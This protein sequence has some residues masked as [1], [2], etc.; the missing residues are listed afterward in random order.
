LAEV[1]R[2]LWKGIGKKGKPTKGVAQTASSAGLPF[3]A[4][5]LH[6]GQSAGSGAGVVGCHQ[7]DRSQSACQ[8]GRFGFAHSRRAYRRAERRAKSGL[9]YAI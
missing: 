3:G 4:L 9:D 7:L 6:Y 5:A 2:I 8:V 1:V